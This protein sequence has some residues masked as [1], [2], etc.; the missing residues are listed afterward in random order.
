MLTLL[1]RVAFARTVAAYEGSDVGLVGVEERFNN[2]AAKIAR[3]LP[4]F[5]QRM[6]YG[7]R[8]VPVEER[9]LT[10]ATATFLMAM[11]RI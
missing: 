3:C 1:G 6:F 2:R 10:P 8:T 7:F 11:V 5:R 9:R 4:G